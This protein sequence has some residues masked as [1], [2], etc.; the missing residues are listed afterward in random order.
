M[1]SD[2][3]NFQF[4]LFKFIDC[5]LFTGF[6]RGSLNSFQILL[7]SGNLFAISFLS[8]IDAQID[9]ALIAS[10]FAVVVEI[11]VVGII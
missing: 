1:V 6:P 10:N 4:V 11:D 9:A 2:T 3:L 8:K 5:V 7:V